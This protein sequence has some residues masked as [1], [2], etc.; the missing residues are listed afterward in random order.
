M[1]PAKD[2]IESKLAKLNIT[3]LSDWGKRLFI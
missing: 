3:G 1:P 2:L